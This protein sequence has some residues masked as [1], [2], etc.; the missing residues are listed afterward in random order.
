M[1]LFLALLYSYLNVSLKGLL[2]EVGFGLFHWF[3]VFVLKF[4]VPIETVCVTCCQCV[5]GLNV[6]SCYEF[7]CR[8]RIERQEAILLGRL[9]SVSL[10]VFLLCSNALYYA[11]P[12]MILRRKLNGE[13]SETTSMFHR[14]CCVQNG[15][16]CFVLLTL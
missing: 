16:I 15:T 12:P 1:K 5:A 13:V 14:N 4:C 11:L 8:R 6:V 10:S 2:N 7:S 3:S 9:E